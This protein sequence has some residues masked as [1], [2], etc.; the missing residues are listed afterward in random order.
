MLTVRSVDMMPRQRMIQTGVQRVENDAYLR[1]KSDE[2][3]Q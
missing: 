3:R 1:V 2:R